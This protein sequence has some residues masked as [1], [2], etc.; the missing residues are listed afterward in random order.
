MHFNFLTR[1]LALLSLFINAF[2]KYFLNFFWF[3]NF[4]LDLGG[5]KN[6]LLLP[7]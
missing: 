2:R 5:D 1:I 7:S 4:F 6:Q 3:F